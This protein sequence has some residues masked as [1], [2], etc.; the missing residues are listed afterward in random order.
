MLADVGPPIEPVWSTADRDEALLW[1]AALEGRGVEGI[2]AK[3]LRSA[4]KA[5]RGRT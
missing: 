5:G 4:D 3:Q 1:Y 2:V